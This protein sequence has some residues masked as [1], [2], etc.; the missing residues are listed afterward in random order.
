MTTKHRQQWSP[1]DY[2]SSATL[3]V[4]RTAATDG[5]DRM[6]SFPL[7]YIMIIMTLNT[8]V[9]MKAYQ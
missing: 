3:S 7:Q 9:R 8:I 5:N 6:A 4:L 2:M 1:F